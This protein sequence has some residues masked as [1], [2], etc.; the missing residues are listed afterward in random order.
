MRIN[1]QKFSI[2]KEIGDD[3]P[4]EGKMERNLVDFD[5]GCY[6]GQEVLTRLHAMGKVQKQVMAIRLG[7][8][9]TFAQP[10]RIGILMEIKQ[11]D[12]LNH[13]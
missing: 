6:L 11:W 2:P 3:L 1:E 8:Q 9:N 13:W 5:K 10:S 7:N 12:K 4:Q